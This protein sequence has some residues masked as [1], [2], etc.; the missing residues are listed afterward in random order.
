MLEAW[1]RRHEVRFGPDGSLAGWLFRTARFV[2]A[3][4]ART[5]RGHGRTLER[6]ARLAPPVDHDVDRRMLDDGRLRESLRLLAELPERDRDVLE[7]A[8][9]SGLSESEMAIALGV[10]VGTLK[11][12]LSRARRRLAERCDTSHPPL[13]LLRS[14]TN[15]EETS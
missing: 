9:W 8:A 1:R 12:C 15:P 14:A 13:A 3:N 7:L 2:L 6:I 11:S 4:D 5:V 10:P